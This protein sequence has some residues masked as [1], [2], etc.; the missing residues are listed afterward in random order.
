M[1][2]E[3]TMA[4]S[5]LLAMSWAAVVTLSSGR[6]SIWPSGPG[7]VLAGPV[8]PASDIG[9]IVMEPDALQSVWPQ[10][11]GSTQSLLAISKGARESRKGLPFLPGLVNQDRHKLAI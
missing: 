5:K 8:P 9:S 6:G 1:R 3:W 2:W 4:T 11:Q 7:S 10:V